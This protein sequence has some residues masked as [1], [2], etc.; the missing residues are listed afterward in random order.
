MSQLIVPIKIAI[1]DRDV[2]NAP[3]I[4]AL[5]QN[6]SGVAAVYLFAESDDVLNA[7]KSDQV[8]ALMIDIFNLGITKGLE[9]IDSV[10]TQYSYAP[11]CLLGDR[12]TLVDLPDIPEKWR[13]RF[14][15]YY[16]LP[17]DQL[18]EQMKK[19]LDEIVRLLA[20]YLRH[21]K[22]YA[23]L[24]EVRNALHHRFENFNALPAEQAEEIDRK[25][26]EAEK[27][28]EVKRQQPLGESYLIQGFAGEDIKRLVTDTLEKASLALEGTARVNK[29]ILICGM[30]LI[31]ASFIVASY[32]QR[33]EAMAFGGFGVAGIIA[34]LV[35]NPLKSIGIGARRLIQLHIAYVGFLKQLALLDT[36]S[37]AHQQVTPLDRSKQL[38][39]AIEKILKALND[40]F[41]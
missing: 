21:S 1:L 20:V 33:W 37:Q 40:N 15:H 24:K 19:S 8:N 10:R 2:F 38:N 4:Q 18:T 5:L 14:D 12:Q 27:A 3:I 36:P 32:T 17:K 11:I 39:E 41:G 9:F 26:E 28:L 25:L 7:F 13:K 22:A 35:T 16:K 6:T 29:W 23:G 30:L 31:I 34:S